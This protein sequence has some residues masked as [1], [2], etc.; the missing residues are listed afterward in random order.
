MRVH[1]VCFLDQDAAAGRVAVP[2]EGCAFGGGEGGGWWGR[3]QKSCRPYLLAGRMA[4][5]VVLKSQIVVGEGSM[6]K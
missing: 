5:T 1:D 2:A 3:S 4:E 6:D